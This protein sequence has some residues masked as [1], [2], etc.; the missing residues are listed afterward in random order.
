MKRSNN[1]DKN[2][3]TKIRKMMCS[4]LIQS[5]LYIRKTNSPFVRLTENG[6]G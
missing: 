6:M 4:I 2:Q 3:Q 5:D 1:L